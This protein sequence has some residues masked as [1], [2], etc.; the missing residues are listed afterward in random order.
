MRVLAVTNMF[1]CSASPAAGVFIEQQIEG[2]L[3]VG[4]Q[5]QVVFVNRQTEGPFAYYRMRPKIEA[6]VAGFCP[7]LI[8][9]MYGG[10]MA[11]QVVR[12]H[13][14]RPVVVTFHGS[15]LLGENLSGWFR[16]IVSHYG[17]ACSKRAAR[18]ADGVVVVARHLL[19][20]LPFAPGSLSPD[21]QVSGFIPQPSMPIVRV[22]P[23][24]I[25][26]DRFRPMDR[27]ACRR[28]LRWEPDIFH[29][30]FVS[31]NGD[32][33]KRPW[34]A[35][36][37][38]ERLAGSGARAE[39]HF[40]AGVPNAEVPCWINASD[41]LLLTSLHE[42][43]PMVVKEA[44]ACGVPIVSVDV[45]DVAERMEG[46]KGC[47]LA[48]P[49]PTDL[50]LKLRMVYER[51]SAGRTS[52]SAPGSTACEHGNRINCGTKLKELSH[53]AVAHALKQ[54]YL[55]IL[56]RSAAASASQVGSCH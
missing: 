53:T 46:I 56:A 9:V 1:P 8:H 40:V 17:V 22:I 45:G 7:D 27:V 15:D 32:P 30:L 3:S 10:V 14:L 35:R 28:Q 25:D 34:L 21:P 38:V 50:A 4:V 33:V 51:G 44:L 2:L 39:L 18:A 43:S 24:G 5:V 41:V 42:G 11:D 48:E 49:N 6:S 52:A 26:P 12:R 29:V 37:A 16:K 55:E 23:C 31:N 36:Q 20:A 47:H 19:K 54:F 13:R